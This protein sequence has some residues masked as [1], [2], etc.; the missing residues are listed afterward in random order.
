MASKLK[1]IP[2]IKGKDRYEAGIFALD[3]LPE[4]SR[5]DLF[6]LDDGFQHWGLFRDNDILL[7][8]GTNP[9]GNGETTSLLAH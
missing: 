5:P 6:I 4:D 7:I 3:N 1:G 2:V 8:D 9:F